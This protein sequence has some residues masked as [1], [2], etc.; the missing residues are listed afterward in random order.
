MAREYKVVS[1]DS[2]VN[3]V[4]SFW[5]EYLPESLRDEAPLLEETNEGDYVTFE[6]ERK[7][8]ASMG[9]QAGRKFKDYAPVKK[10]SETRSGGWVPQ[11]RIE[12]MD[13]DGVDAEII[14]GGGPLSTANLGLHL[15]S[16]G[17]YNNWLADFCSHDP[18][19]LLGIAYIPMVDVERAITDLKHSASRG[20][21]GSVIVAFPPAKEGI[22]PGGL[23]LS[24]DPNRNY[25]DP[26]FDP[27]WRA[28]IELDM[29]VHMHLGARKYPGGPERWMI[30]LTS[31]KFGMAEPI[32]VFIF[33]GLLAKYPELTLTSVESGVGWMAF[34]IEYMDHLYERHQYWT[35]SPL[36]EP[37]SFY[38]HRQVRGHVPARPGG[39]PG[40]PCH[41]RGQPHVVVRLSP[42]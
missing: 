30:N 34:L 9:A 26:E 10:V 8:F 14:Y 40:A 15:A 36:K 1:A 20:L 32:S 35:Q 42:L 28:S 3:P 24:G 41:R 27:Y 13:V 38:F 37:P 17:A 6:G 22:L 16:Y 25:A 11:D 21:R 5:R 29:P 12:D 7:L 23:A 31:S 4:P 39:R 19:R 18:E 33:T 2:H